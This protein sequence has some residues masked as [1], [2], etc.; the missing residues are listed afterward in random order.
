MGLIYGEEEQE[1]NSTSWSF[2]YVFFFG[3]FVSVGVVLFLLVCCLDGYQ[4][5]FPC[6]QVLWPEPWGTMNFWKRDVN[7]NKRFQQGG[8]PPQVAKNR[9]FQRR[10][11][12][13]LKRWNLLETE[14]PTH[15][16]SVPNTCPSP[17]NKNSLVAWKSRCGE[18]WL[19]GYLAS[20]L[21][22][23]FWIRF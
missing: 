8:V 7:K 14:D 9:P 20:S 16:E 22:W 23:S 4:R 2:S 5:S 11:I 19:F 6:S 10:Q 17:G 12:R 21:S 1:M 13:V 3:I 15:F 18:E